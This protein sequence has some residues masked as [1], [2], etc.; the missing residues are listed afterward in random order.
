[1]PVV[2]CAAILYMPSSPANI[3]P[4]DP[5]QGHPERSNSSSPS[6]SPVTILLS[7]LSVLSAVFIAYLVHSSTTTTT[8]TASADQ[9]T[10]TVTRFFP[11]S[12]LLNRQSVVRQ[13]SN[14]AALQ[15]KSNLAN[16]RAEETGI[17]MRT[18][19]Y[20]ISHGG[21]GFFILILIYF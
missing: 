20:F 17:K 5:S 4:K 12:R 8:T 6:T 7:I 2:P 16:L 18:P 15:A 9:D 10:A 1:M 11:F 14:S 3:P 19:V 21:V 13:V